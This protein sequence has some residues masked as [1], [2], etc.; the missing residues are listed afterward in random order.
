M[1]KIIVTLVTL[2]GF[3]P[4]S[5][6]THCQTLDT[7]M[8][9]FLD[10]RAGDTVL[11]PIYLRNHTFAVGGIATRVV[12]T[13]STSL[14]IINFYRGQAI[15]NFAYYSGA[16]TGG[17]ARLIT[18]ANMPNY[19]PIAPLYPGIHEIAKIRVA[20][21]ESLQYG[22]YTIIFSDRIGSPITSIADSSGYLV[23]VPYTLDGVVNYERPSPI[24]IEIPNAENF[25]LADCYPNPFN[26]NTNIEFTIAKPGFVSL[27]IYDIMGRKVINLFDHFTN[28][29]SYQVTW[30]GKSIDG[31]PLSSGV[32]FYR[33][34]FDNNG[35]TKKFSLVK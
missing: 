2:M 25:S 33:L 34:T 1:K 19:E 27:D 8:M 29:G 15:L 31:K 22:S 16:F 5:G 9:P 7:L 23:R 20:V 18:M 3:L 14:R 10:V 17:S 30:D 24:D 4:L 28:T 11:I 32:Y 21:S 35:V 12:L 26:S 13:D 6:F